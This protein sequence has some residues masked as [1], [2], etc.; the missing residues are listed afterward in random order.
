[1][2]ESAEIRHGDATKKTLHDSSPPPPLHIMNT[3]I[4]PFRS[5]VSPVRLRVAFGGDFCPGPHGSALAKAGRADEV[6]A[7]LAPFLADA[8]LKLVQFETPLVTR[9]SPIPKSGPN[10]DSEPES[11]E[12]LRG[13]FDVALLANNHVGD[14]GP[15]A[16]LQTV[17]ELRRRGIETVGAGATLAEA[18][19]PL[20]TVRRGVR[21]AV[22][23][24]AEFEFGV[25]EEDSPGVA[26]Q[27]PLKDLAAVAKAAERGL[28][29]VV[30]L[31][32]G[33]EHFPFPS[34]R[35]RDLC[36]AFAESGAAFVANCHPHCP[37]GVEWHRGVPIVYC[38]GNLWFPAGSGIG[39]A[40]Q[41]PL[42]NFGYVAKVLFDHAGAF[43]V[44]LLPV[45]S[46]QDGVR[47]LEGAARDAFEAYVARVSEPI[48][49]TARLR[50]LFDAWS[51]DLGRFYL[52]MS[53]SRL[54][55][56]FFADRHADSW[57]SP[58]GDAKPF[59]E[60]R[61]V[62]TCE[63]HCDMVRR[64]LRLAETGRIPDAMHR[65]P[66]IAALRNPA[67]VLPSPPPLRPRAE[68]L[69]F[70]ERSVFGRV[71]DA[72]KRAAPEFE[73]LSPEVPAMGGRAVRRRVRVRYAGPGGEG[74]FDLLAFLPATAS[75]SR[76]APAALL[77]CNR[78][79]AEN[80]D[81]ERVRRTPFW[82]AERIVSRGWAALAFHT[83]SVVP[84][85]ADGFDGHLQSL[86]LRPGEARGPDSWGTIAAWAWCGSRAMDWIETERRI[87]PRR[88][89]VAGHS[90]GGKTALW[91]AARDERFAMA[92]SNCSGCGGAKLNRAFLPASEHVAQLV[93]GFPHWFCEAFSGFAGRDAELPFDQHQLLALLA[94]RK[95]YVSS[96]TLD[97]WAGQPGEFLAAALASPAWGG[98]GRGGIPAGTAFP[99]PDAPLFGDG[100]AYHIHRGPHTILS[101][102]WDHWIDFAEA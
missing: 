60:M 82:D 13:R 25:A 70:F 61:N 62:F 20:E 78:D 94:P 84:D 71:P 96:A 10:L 47:P 38:P 32:G 85:G 45:Q 19:R 76:P 37:Q 101:S 24:F 14:H 97:P 18:A 9:T 22:F 35:L 87:D 58:L 43:A 40:R 54:P 44:E 88:V 4:R 63:S 80:M 64:F 90:R 8:D 6:F 99:P 28:L 23:N 2:I 92:V 59:L 21:I 93:A 11:A 98:D 39:S 36:R 57:E 29:P 5:P 48:G 95:L 75:A 50:S 79:P 31:H 100:V 68:T 16:A 55:A 46:G 41:P 30:V 67:F 91:C 81:P 34:P 77:L 27:R 33:H 51:A 7:P 26:P 74:H 49:D 56:P 72:A 66:E 86:F 83:G 12:I 1:M 73:D 3:I 89:M 52:K 65:C 53:A 102:D 42:W 15:D 17:A 69:D